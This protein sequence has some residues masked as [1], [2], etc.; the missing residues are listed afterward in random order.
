MT[1]KIGK[2]LPQ[3]IGCGA[4]W[5]TDRMP[6]YQSREPMFES[7]CF[8]AWTLLFPP[9]CLSTHSCINAYLSIA[10]G[11]YI[12]MMGLLYKVIAVWINNKELILVRDDTPYSSNGNCKFDQIRGAIPES[13]KWL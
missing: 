11:G 2:N 12:W 6:D 3:Q 1:K 7:C 4:L 10:S 13:C 9:R 5:L 8:W